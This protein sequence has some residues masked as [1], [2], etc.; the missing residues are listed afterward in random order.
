MAKDGPYPNFAVN[1]LM[2][3]N[4]IDTKI[5]HTLK[6]IFFL[7]FSLSTKDDEFAGLP[8]EDE[9][10]VKH[11]KKY[12]SSPISK[13]M[14]NKIQMFDFTLENIIPLFFGALYLIFY[15]FGRRSMKKDINQFEN[16]L[17]PELRK[18][19]AVVPDHFKMEKYG[20]FYTYVTG[21]SRYNG[22][23]IF[24]KFPRKCDPLFYLWDLIF[25]NEISVTFDSCV[26]PYMESTAIFY[27]SHEKIP[28]RI[29]ELKLKEVI[30]KSGTVYHTDFGTSCE[31]FVQIIDNFLTKT[32]ISIQ[33]L[34]MTDLNHYHSQNDGRFTV[35]LECKGKNLF[36]E[37]LKS[38]VYL[39]V[40][41]SDKFILLTLTPEQFEINA[42][43]RRELI[44]NG[45]LSEER[46][47]SNNKI[48]KE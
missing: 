2:N 45:K 15:I 39:S 19:F 32:N 4:S 36:E 33:T 44:S 43:V 18:Y 14:N 42:L 24:V 1:N 34:E 46:K 21:R 16:I 27:L 38:I 26:E 37:E 23:Y 3:Q 20:S 47:E 8:L 31:S 35:F 25:H 5:F 41:L 11:P 12:S 30:S 9:E 28:L 29:S 7:I 6:M 22:I 13:P 48:K 17:I 40:E 10:L